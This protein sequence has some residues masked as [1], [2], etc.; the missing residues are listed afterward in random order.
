VRTDAAAKFLVKP[1]KCALCVCGMQL[2]AWSVSDEEEIDIR[3]PTYGS[4]SGVWYCG[5]HGKRASA[6]QGAPSPVAPG[7]RVP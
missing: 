2:V 4:A 3:L 7:M 1:I 5:F 6:G